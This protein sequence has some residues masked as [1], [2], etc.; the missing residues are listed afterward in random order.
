MKY[1][2]LNPLDKNRAEVR[3][4]VLLEGNK[5][6]EL[7]EIREKRTV[8]QNSYIHVLFNLYALCFGST[9]DEAKTDLKRACSFMTYEKNGRKYLRK[10]SK[11]NTKELTEF[12]EW[13]RTYSAQHGN[14]LPTP[15]EYRLNSIEIDKEIERNKEW[16]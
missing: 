12:I 2:L 1:R 8:S 13:I 11:M 14:Y 10:T 4:K 9:L 16:L 3:F 15:S 7:K 5:D 6:I